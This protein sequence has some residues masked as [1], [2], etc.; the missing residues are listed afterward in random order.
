[1]RRTLLWLVLALLAPQAQAHE[2]WLLPDRFSLQPG[3]EA[4]LTLFV[5]EQFRGE[6][7]PVTAGRRMALR[8]FRPDSPH[9]VA[10]AVQP[11]RLPAADLRW[12]PEEAGTHLITF[13]GPPSLSELSAGKFHAYLHEEGLDFIIAA[14]KAAGT[15]ETPGR[16]R[17]RRCAKSVLR[18]GAASNGV[19]TR[20][21]GQRLE[22]ILLAEPHALR[23]REALP[24]QLR[25]DDKP[26]AG[27]LIKAWH[28]DAA[29]TTVL[30]AVTSDE[31]KVRFTLPFAGV[32]MLS[33][34]HMIAVTGEEDA[35][36]DS[37]WASLTFALDG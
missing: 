15:E 19:A 29:Q 25:F 27:A 20:K 32:W 3:D 33:V 1:M 16:E 36:W 31:G 24:V 26:L 34:V 21:V 2:F 30:R 8:H 18:V 22:L 10:L 5:G 6:A 14:R 4:R 9:G 37:Y 17:Y 35:D 23:V 12:R 11:G 28:R 13:D 7:L